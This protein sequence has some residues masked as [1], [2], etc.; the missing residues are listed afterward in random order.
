MVR[1]LND[2][3][4]GFSFAQKKYGH[5]KEVMEEAYK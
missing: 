3:R 1:A 2:E 4:A 5:S